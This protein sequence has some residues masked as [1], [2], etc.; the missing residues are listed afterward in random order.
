MLRNFLNVPAFFSDLPGLVPVIPFEQSGEFS[1]T[2]PFL[3]RLCW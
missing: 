1:Q 3:L 2:L